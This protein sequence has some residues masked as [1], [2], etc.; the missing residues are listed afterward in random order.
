MKIG[1]TLYLKNRKEWRRWLE[2]S[3]Q[4]EPEIWLICYKKHTGKTSIPYNDAVEEALC[5]GWIDSNEKGI[6]REKYAQRFSPRKPKSN[7][8]VVNKERVRRLIKLGKMTPAGLK[9]FPK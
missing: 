3:H 1:K 7:W 8:S 2:K 9:Y 4:K 6:D 5:Y